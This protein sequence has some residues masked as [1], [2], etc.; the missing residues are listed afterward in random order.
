MLLRIAP[1]MNKASMNSALSSTWALILYTSDH[2]VDH[3]HS[4][5]LANL[6]RQLSVGLDDDRRFNRSLDLL[7]MSLKTC[8]LLNQIPKKP[9][10][11][12]ALLDEIQALQKRLQ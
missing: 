11:A 3:T 5:E 6:V 12:S 2:I 4:D 9:K 7:I 1:R 8:G 10:G